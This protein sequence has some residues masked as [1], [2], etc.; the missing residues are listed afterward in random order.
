MKKLNKED[1][2]IEFLSELELET[3][4]AGDDGDAEAQAYSQYCG[5]SPSSKCVSITV[6][7]VSVTSTTK[8]SNA[9]NTYTELSCC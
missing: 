1:F 9:T 4:T 7:L 5:T 3:T 6:S 8:C 2:N